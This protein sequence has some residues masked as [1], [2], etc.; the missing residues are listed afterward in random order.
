MDN[1]GHPKGAMGGKADGLAFPVMSKGSPYFP[2]DGRC[3]W[4][5]NNSVNEPHSMAILNGGALMM[6]ADRTCGEMD[7]RLDGFLS[8]IWHGAHG[9]GTG[10]FPGKGAMVRVAD[11][12]AGGQFE[13]YFCSTDCLRGFLNHCVDKLEDSIRTDG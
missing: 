4:C 13:M 3:P 11:N 8:L 9:S 1:E 7:D 12:C 6:N 5:N 10:I 2:T